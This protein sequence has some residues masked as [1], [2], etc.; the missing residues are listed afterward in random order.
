MERTRRRNAPEKI[1][2]KHLFPILDTIP[3]SSFGTNPSIVHQYGDLGRDEFIIKEKSMGL[4][5]GEFGDGR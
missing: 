3:R 5:I 1:N 4:G 2:I